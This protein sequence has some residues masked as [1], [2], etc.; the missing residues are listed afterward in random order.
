MPDERVEQ[1]VDAG[2]AA[3]HM[4]PQRLA[5]LPE[6]RLA[7]DAAGRER[8]HRA[9]GIGACEMVEG[10]ASAVGI[11]ADDGEHRLAGGGFERRLPTLV[12]HH[13]VEQGAE[14]AVDRRDPLGAGPS[15]GR[16]E[17]EGEGFGT[18]RHCDSSAAA[19]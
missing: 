10:A 16:V 2:V 9:V 13:E 19:S 18:G 11:G 4:R 5:A 15:A 1:R 8:E 12:D 14:H 7:P 17:R 3:A 6:A